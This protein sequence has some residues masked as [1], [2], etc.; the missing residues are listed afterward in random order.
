M[1]QKSI[2]LGL[3]LFGFLHTNITSN[4]IDFIKNCSNVL[5]EKPT[6]EEIILE[7][8]GKV[9]YVDFWASW[10]APC[11]MEMPTSLKLQN[12]YTD[13]EVV[14][15]YISIDHDFLEWRQASK[16][17]HIDGLKYN[18][19]ASQIKKSEIS[20]KIDL[21]SIPKYLLFDK[22][23]NLVNTDAPSPD[24][25]EIKIKINKYLKE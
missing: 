17:E 5:Q 18:L 8:K 21:K 3:F 14:F 23:G 2:C 4:E 10:C 12:E 19:L 15:I 16:K 20:K 6:L 11:R 1:L 13:K 9:I 22:E 25:K 24:S 7:N